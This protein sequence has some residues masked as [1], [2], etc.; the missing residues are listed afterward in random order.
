[1]L[2]VQFSDETETVII[3]YFA[4]PQN[5]EYYDFLGEVEV[6]DP[7]YVIFYNSMPNDI[8]QYLPTP[9]FSSGS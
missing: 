7:R 9:T 1:M 4:S 6:D 3:S 8:K 2:Y 5:P